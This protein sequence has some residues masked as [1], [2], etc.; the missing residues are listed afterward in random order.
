[1]VDEYRSH[2][3]VTF[4]MNVTNRLAVTRLRDFILKHA[5]QHPVDPL[6]LTLT[7][8][9]KDVLLYRDFVLLT[10]IQCLLEELAIP[11]SVH[12][13]LL[14]LHQLGFVA[15]AQRVGLLEHCIANH[16]MLFDNVGRVLSGVA[17][18]EKQATLKMLRVETTTDSSKTI[19]A[20][21]LGVLCELGVAIEIQGN[22]VVDCLLPPSEEIPQG[23][24][25]QIAMKSTLDNQFDSIWAR[26]IRSPAIL[27]RLSSS[28]LS[29]HS[30]DPHICA[31]LNIQACK[32]R[33]GLLQWNP[34]I[35][36]S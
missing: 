36:S 27:S 1:M 24:A 7:E 19:T 13:A 32:A 4:R 33:C 17:I 29:R 31:S 9:V 23:N 15:Y 20:N 10:E 12:D 34:R 18:A 11:L 35:R 30:N 22:I 2:I 26:L 16:H 28:G 14:K 5:L 3:L 25:L 21:L 8:R 6:T